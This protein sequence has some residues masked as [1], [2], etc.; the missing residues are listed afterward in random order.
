MRSVFLKDGLSGSLN[1]DQS[2][3]TVCTESLFYVLEGHNA[4]FFFF[5]NKI[6]NKPTFKHSRVTKHN[7]LCQ[8]V[9]LATLKSSVISH[10]D[11][12]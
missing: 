3:G 6:I 5:E 4:G 10:V 7:S 2:V 12:H 11:H 9:T 8:T 1:D